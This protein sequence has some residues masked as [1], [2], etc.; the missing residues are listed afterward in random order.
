MSAPLR[1]ALVH[2][3]LTGMRGGEKALEVLC[4]KYP[5]ATLFTLFHT[6][7]RVSPVIER[8]RPRSS[9]LQSLPL[10]GR[11]YRHFLPLFPFAIEQFDL[12]SYDLVISTSH[13]AAKSV[14]VP[15]RTPHL[16]YCHSPMRYAWDQYDS[17]FGPQR[18]GA[19]RSRAIRPVIAALAR[20]DA[21]TATRV[22]RFLANSKHVARRIGRYY[23]RRA[24]VVYP[25]VDTTFYY[26]DD[27]VLGDY[28][29]MV[30]ALVPYKRV[31]VAIQACGMIGAP[32]RIVGQG[33]E[34]ARLQ[35]M[36]GPTVEFLGALPDAE[37][38]RL[39]L[40]AQALLLPG[41]EDFGIAP[42][43]AQACGRPVVALAR[44]GALETI[45]HEVTG[46]L[47]TQDSPDAFA[48]GLEAV[49]RA[50]FDPDAARTR[51][52]RFSREQFAQSIEAHVR[53]TMTAPTDRLRW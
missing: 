32:L 18:L 19:L 50:S 40:G 24:A 14:V 3:W 35:R 30:S 13:C 6:K 8:L 10:A 46:I 42:V 11:Y 2:D 37:I 39:Y 45:E 15:G 52:L 36:A 16:C 22:D 20:W 44:G 49:R 5:T 4:E 53:D 51:A 21:R 27:S 25:P 33:P 47:V 29:L 26:P 12:D 48:E 28:F 23:N 9:I 1:I 7:G 34:L 41:E 31:E 43:E 38:R 17:Y